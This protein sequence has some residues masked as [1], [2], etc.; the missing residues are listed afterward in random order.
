[1]KILRKK[2][3]P[4]NLFYLIIVV[5][6]IILI[7]IIVNLI[8]TW[9][10]LQGGFLAFLTVTAIGMLVNW[11]LLYIGQIQCNEGKF[12]LVI[13]PECI[14]Y[15]GENAFGKPFSRVLAEFDNFHL[16]VIFR[17][18]FFED[19]IYKKNILTGKKKL[20]LPGGIYEKN[21][22]EIVA[23]ISQI[24]STEK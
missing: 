23:I 24:S 7:S 10:N 8:N 2:T 11:Y 22:E 15:H 5:W 1:M 12:F 6:G 20:V 16:F 21:G 19:A 9:S 14:R 4:K 13:E 3:L 18:V 17:D